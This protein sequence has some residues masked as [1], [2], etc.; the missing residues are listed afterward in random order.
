MGTCHDQHG[1]TNPPLRLTPACA[2]MQRRRP[3]GLAEHCCSALAAAAAAGRGSQAFNAWPNA[4]QAPPPWEVQVF[5]GRHRPSTSPTCAL[6]LGLDAWPHPRSLQWEYRASPA[7]AHRVLTQRVRCQHVC[8]VRAAVTTKTGQRSLL[9]R[10]TTCTTQHPYAVAGRPAADR[11][12]QPW[13]APSVAA[14]PPP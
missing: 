9:L 8:Y 2:I 1:M 5:L 13:F 3:C 10:C 6:H 4:P 12:V 7:V 11:L 14:S